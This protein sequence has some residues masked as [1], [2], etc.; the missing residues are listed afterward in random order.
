MR[1]YSRN[2]YTARIREQL[3]QHHRDLA[4]AWEDWIDSGRTAQATRQL[5]ARCECAGMHVS[6]LLRHEIE[7]ETHS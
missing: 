6:A 1:G 4:G 2:A 5:L 3:R 7:Q